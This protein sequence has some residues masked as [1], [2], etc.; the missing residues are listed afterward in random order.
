MYF[1]RKC[2]TDK[3]AH[4]FSKL[5][6][7]WLRCRCCVKAA[8]D[9][10][11]ARRRFEKLN[12]IVKDTTIKTCKVCGE[13]KSVDLFPKTGKT[14]KACKKIQNSTPEKKKKQAEYSKSYHQRHPNKR[15]ERYER[16]KEKVL[17]QDKVY[18]EKNRDRILKR[19]RE[20]Y[21]NNREE[22]RAR[23]NLRRNTPEHKEYMSEYHKKW[24]AENKEEKLRKNKEWSSKNR[25]RVNQTN[26]AWVKNNQEHVRER[27]RQYNLKNKD[28]LA[29]KRKIRLQNRRKTDV[30]FRL[31]NNLR[32]S[33][34]NSIKNEWK[35]SSALDLLGMTV[36]EFKKY[37]ESLWSPGMSWSNWGNGE[38]CWNIDHIKPIAQFNLENY[39]EQKICFHFSNLRPLWWSENNSKKD[40]IEIDGQRIRASIAKK[41][42]LI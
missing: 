12:N 17:A 18:R 38:N 15:K 10:G 34:Y 35:K 24:Y 7:D 8:N 36:P 40:W 9:E 11:H 2:K 28:R 4:E 3:P 6:S 19:N 31:S 25:D 26:R 33:L 16:D 5:D 1:C 23:E 22:I 14:C 20:H 41:E 29:E 21:Q 27:N 32:G 39:E 13:T 37:L 42:G 30:N